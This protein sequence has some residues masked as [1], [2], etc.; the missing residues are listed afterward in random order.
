MFLLIAFNQSIG[1]IV[2][3]V[4]TYKSFTKGALLE[5]ISCLYSCILKN[6]YHIACLTNYCHCLHC[7]ECQL[8]YVGVW[9]QS[10][11]INKPICFPGTAAYICDVCCISM[12][13]SRCVNSYSHLPQKS[14]SSALLLCWCFRVGR[15]CHTTKVHI[16]LHTSSH[17]S[18]I[19][20]SFSMGDLKVNA[21]WLVWLYCGAHSAVQQAAVTVF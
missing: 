1:L 6:K 13:M 21:T 3:K 8:V 15:W 5:I 14:P 11:P 16:F 20:R 17:K 7:E 12:K 19:W 4:T 9:E 10:R 2:N 18:K